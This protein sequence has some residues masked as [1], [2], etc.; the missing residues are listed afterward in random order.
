[1]N[2]SI[3]N[4]CIVLLLVLGATVTQAGADVFTVDVNGGGNFTTIQDAVNQ[5]NVGDTIVVNPG[6]Y[7]ENIAVN[8]ELTILSNPALSTNNMRTYVLGTVSENGIFDVNSNNV[9]I[10]GFYIIGGSSGLNREEAG[11]NL[12]GVE[13]CSISNNK[14]IL[15]DVGV[16]L[17]GSKKNYLESNLVSLGSKGIALVNSDENILYNNTITTNSEGISLNNSMNNTFFNNIADANMVGIYLRMAQ[18]N[19]LTYN[20]IMRNINGVKGETAKSNY[21]VNNTLYLNDIGI[22][23]T[24][25]SENSIYENQ[26]DNLLD[27]VDDGK[28]LWNST[29]KGNFWHNYT[30]QDADGNGIGDTPYVINQ[31][32]GSIDYMPILS[33]NAT[34]NVSG[35]TPENTDN[36]STV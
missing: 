3:Q 5:A 17:N 30:G 31:M 33:I 34:E 36:S 35:S 27:A 11:I 15:N 1:M 29:S 24:E 23:L 26:F 16:A 21:M 19:M 18:G 2:R 8:K 25:S 14:L 32:T 22:N 12:N 9:K 6:V 7:R 28:N 13:N 4:I 10:D 20:I